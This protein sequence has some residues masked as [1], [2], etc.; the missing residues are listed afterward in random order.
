M[1]GLADP[2]TGVSGSCIVHLSWSTLWD[3]R[4]WT[5]TTLRGTMKGGKETLLLRL[6]WCWPVARQQG[7]ATPLVLATEACERVSIVIDF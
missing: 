5:I 4:I 7:L 6:L 3:R 1:A 2:D